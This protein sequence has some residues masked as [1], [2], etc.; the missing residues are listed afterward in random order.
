MTLTHRLSKNRSRRN[1]PPVTLGG[2]HICAGAVATCR[3][4]QND[5]HAPSFPKPF[6]APKKAAPRLRNR[7]FTPGN[8]QICFHFEPAGSGNNPA[9]RARRGSNPR[10]HNPQPGS[11]PR[12]HKPQ[13]DSNPRQPDS[14]PRSHASKK[15]SP[16][17]LEPTSPARQA[18]HS[19]AKPRP[20]VQ[21]HPLF[22]HIKPSL[23][24][25]PSCI[26]VKLKGPVAGRA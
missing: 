13:P 8:S 3:A 24:R 18:A 1:T 6:Q 4:S 25:V 11:N 23:E 19:T 26:R 2:N 5:R 12:H 15:L 7:D 14:N 17:G 9:S 10:H 16:P 20:L 22:G 21:I